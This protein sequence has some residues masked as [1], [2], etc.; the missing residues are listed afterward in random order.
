M[1][2]QRP[3]PGSRVV[4]GAAVGAEEHDSDSRSRAI[5]FRSVRG[6]DGGL[7]RRGGRPGR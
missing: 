7:E 2:A 6:L 1:T 5:S 4:A 3:P